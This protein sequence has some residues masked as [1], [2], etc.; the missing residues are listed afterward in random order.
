[1]QPIHPPVC[2]CKMERIQR[3]HPKPIWTQGEHLKHQTDSNLSAGWNQG[4]WSYQV[5]TQPTQMN[6]SIYKLFDFI[7]FFRF[8]R[9]SIYRGFSTMKFSHLDQYKVLYV[10]LAITIIQ[11]CK[12][13]TVSS[14]KTLSR[15]W[16]HKKQCVVI[17]STGPCQKS[18]IHTFVWCFRK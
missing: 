1:M 2:F 12:P 18:W 6:D 17:I 15:A 11:S 14:V 10:L 4:P 16:Q 8:K 3:T 13:A 5:A 9:L 7:L